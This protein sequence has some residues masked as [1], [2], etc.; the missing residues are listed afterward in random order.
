MFKIVIVIPSIF[1]R[2]H[3]GYSLLYL[4]LLCV[5]YAFVLS[6]HILHRYY[7]GTDNIKSDKKNV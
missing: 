2:L 4:S 3:S 1:L 7:P 5:V 6:T